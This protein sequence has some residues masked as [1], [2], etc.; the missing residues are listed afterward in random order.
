[1]PRHQAGGMNPPAP[2]PANCG[3][4]APSSRGS[5][6]D[7]KTTKVCLAYIAISTTICACILHTLNTSTLPTHTQTLSAFFRVSKPSHI[8][9][10]DVVLHENRPQLRGQSVDRTVGDVSHEGRLAGAVGAQ[11][12]IP[13]SSSETDKTWGRETKVTGRLRERR[14]HGEETR[15]TGGV[16]IHNH[17]TLQHHYLNWYPTPVLTMKTTPKTTTATRAGSR[18]YRCPANRRGPGGARCTGFSMGSQGNLQLQ[19][20]N[21]SGVQS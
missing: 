13:A 14:R 7:G 11:Q 18:A 19:K 5:V 12:S 4:N 16:E 15:D 17:G 8:T 9:G 10:D 1:M 21:T 2:P 6:V 20:R 3:H